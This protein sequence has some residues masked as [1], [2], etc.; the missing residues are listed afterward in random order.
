[1]GAEVA[2][3]PSPAGQG[4]VLVLMTREGGYSGPGRTRLGSAR[5]YLTPRPFAL[6]RVEHKR[7]EA[8]RRLG[9]NRRLGARVLT[10]PLPVSIATPGVARTSPLPRSERPNKVFPGP[11]GAAGGEPRPRARGSCAHAAE[12][13]ADSAGGRGPGLG[14]REPRGTQSEGRRW[15]SPGSGAQRGKQTHARP[16][17]RPA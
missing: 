14:A 13:G 9:A 8:A 6:R 11:G 17:P 16:G 10:G 12:L 5:A 7:E 4:P 1:M 15:E 3:F 2:P